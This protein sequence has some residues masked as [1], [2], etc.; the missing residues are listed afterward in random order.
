[1]TAP[2][3]ED[4]LSLARVTPVASGSDLDKVLPQVNRFPPPDPA[5]ATAGSAWPGSSAVIAEDVAEGVRFDGVRVSSL[6]WLFM[7][8]G[9]SLPLCI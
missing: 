3:L 1:M 2:L 9:S 7:A 8:S 6:D 4:P 5:G